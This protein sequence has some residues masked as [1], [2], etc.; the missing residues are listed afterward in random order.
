MCI[1]FCLSD[2]SLC[3]VM[4]CQILA[5]CVFDL[6][7]Y[8]CYQFVSDSFI[9]IGEAYESYIQFFL[10]CE[11]F[12]IIIAECSC[13]LTC[14]V[15]T[16]V[17]E[18]NRIFILN[19]CNRFAVFFD[20]GRQNEFIGLFCIVGSL[21]SFCCVC[22]FYAFTLC[23]GFEC[24]FYTIPA[25]ITIHCIVTSC[26]GCDLANT[27]FFHLSL[28]LFYITFSGCRRSVTAIQEAVYIYFFQTFSF[29]QFQ[30]TIQMCIVAVYTTIR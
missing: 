1:F 9:V 27:N 11:T 28:Q 8:E 20:N 14:T 7:F 17:E 30:Q 4:S 16:E 21:Y 26:N 25:V 23:H 13:D 18:Y 2:T 19:G 10:T 6:L 3:H 12:E 29:C 22:S 15:R 24:Q 5:E